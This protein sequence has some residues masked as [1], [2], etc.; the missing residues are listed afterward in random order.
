MKSQ[1]GYVINVIVTGFMAVVV[2][3]TVLFVGRFFCTHGLLALMPYDMAGAEKSPS[4]LLDE[5]DRWPDGA[6]SE[7]NT[8]A[9]PSRIECRTSSFLIS[10]GIFQYLESMYQDRYDQ[11]ISP[12]IRTIVGRKNVREPWYLVY[13]DESLGLFVSCRVDRQGVSRKGQWT[14]IIDSY[15][16]PNGISNKPDRAIG[17][18]TQ[19]MLGRMGIVFDRKLSQFVRINFWSKEVKRGP[20]V[21]QEIVQVWQLQKNDGA[22]AG[23]YWKPPMREVLKEEKRPDG[24][25]KSHIRYEPITG[26]L[27]ADVLRDTELVLD[28]AGAI[29]KLDIETLEMTGP[30]GR[31]P[32]PGSRGLLAY[33]IWWFSIKDEHAGLIAGCIGPDIFRPGFLVFDEKGNQIGEEWGDIELSQFA[34]GPALS[35]TNFVLETLQPTILQLAAYFTSFRFD[36]ADG[37][38]SLFVLPNSLV[39]RKGAD[40]SREG[41]VEYI[42]GLWVT[43]PSLA[44]SVILACRVEKDARKIGLSARAK[45]CWMVVTVAFGLTAYITYRLT[46]PTI[47]LVTCANCG[48]PRRPDMDRCHRCG[49]KWLVPEL[50]P[51]LWRVIEKSR[52]DQSQALSPDLPGH[53]NS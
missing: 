35:I 31:L 50:V 49:S 30:V 37:P 10:L 18:F 19:P 46:R 52:P 2:L 28:K 11:L 40:C 25:I 33:D 14:K 48:R 41:L 15:A 21:E 38:R 27:G 29:Y 43:L 13:F 39:G 6:I 9:K 1:K 4:G 47:A 23:P 44:I 36:G 20:K 3:S 12:Y 45:F 17:R 24:K 53:Q 26:Y 22:I 34:G 16:G 32:W 51:P 42:L 8:V 7:P 5:W